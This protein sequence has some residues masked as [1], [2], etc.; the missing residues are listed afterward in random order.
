[1]LFT[2]IELICRVS[3]AFLWHD[4]LEVIN[5]S[6]FENI[7]V[8]E[9]LEHWGQFICEVFKIDFI[10][11]A[12]LQ[13]RENGT[14]WHKPLL[15]HSFHLVDLRVNFHLSIRPLLELFALISFKL[16]GH[17]LELSFNDSIFHLFIPF[18][19]RNTGHFIMG[20]CVDVHL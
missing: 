10:L 16:R 20:S 7:R 8:W 11:I 3:F 5:L 18:S 6:G 14:L 1:V 4:V 13:L 15:F 12:F 2:A 17:L 9:T 19:W